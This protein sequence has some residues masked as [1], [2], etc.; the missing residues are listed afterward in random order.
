MQG[1]LPGARRL[2]R[3]GVTTWAIEVAWHRAIHAPGLMAAFQQ[4]MRN[5]HDQEN[6][7][8]GTAGTD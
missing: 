2:T 4:G 6:P 8:D 5:V 7:A 3:T 1:L